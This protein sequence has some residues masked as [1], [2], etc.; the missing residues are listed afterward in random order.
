[1]NAAIL[2]IVSTAP[3]REI[4]VKLKDIFITKEKEDVNLGKVLLIIAQRT[5]SN[6]FYIRCYDNGISLIPA[7]IRIFIR[8]DMPLLNSLAALDQISEDIID[9]IAEDYI[10]MAYEM[11]REQSLVPRTIN[12]KEIKRKVVELRQI[13]GAMS[14]SK[15]HELVSSHED[16][17]VGWDSMLS[18]IR[19]FDPDVSHDTDDQELDFLHG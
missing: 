19:Y 5:K 7:I 4:L 12:I 14:R 8:N 10:E 17:T 13:I 9:G 3:P 16:S 15:F 1:M 11:V 6:P 18:C 2:D